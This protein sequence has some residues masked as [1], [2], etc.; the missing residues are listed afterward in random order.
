MRLLDERKQLFRDMQ[1]NSDDYSDEQIEELMDDIDHT[2]DVE[3]EWKKF[4]STHFA[5][6][7]KITMPYWFNKIA[8]M[9]AI[10]ITTGIVYA[11]SVAIGIITNPFTRTESPSTHAVVKA[12]VKTSAKT[13]CD[14]TGLMQTIIEPVIFDGAQ[15]Y[16]ILDEF[17]TYYNVKVEY[18]SDKA[19][20]I[21]LFFKWD[22]KKEL[23]NNIE[24]LNSFE[25]I[26]ISLTDSIIVVK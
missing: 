10:I 20:S 4:E 12:E 24:A 2:P 8:A 13:E 23:C 19:K 25:R 21:R 15:L 5:T 14:T 22:K 17:S 3:A 9:I 6:E 26:N 7:K 16:Q 18:T 1:S 11:A